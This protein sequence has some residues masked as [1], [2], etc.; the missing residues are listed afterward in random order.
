MKCIS[1]IKNTLVFMMIKFGNELSVISTYETS[2][3]DQNQLNYAHICEL[4]Q[5][6]EQLLALQVNNSD[7]QV[8]LQLDDDVD[9]IIGYKKKIVQ[10]NWKNCIARIK[11]SSYYQMVPPNDETSW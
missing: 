3:L 8:D 6:N 1:W 2:H 5:Q 11:G 9:D 10:P 7:N 4:Q